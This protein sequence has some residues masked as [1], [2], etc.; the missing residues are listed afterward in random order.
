MGREDALL[1]LRMV[2]RRREESLGNSLRKQIWI[3]L[4]GGGE[5]DVLRVEEEDVVCL[6]CRRKI[7]E[8]KI[9]AVFQ[10]LFGLSNSR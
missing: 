5:S 7:E 10:A 8:V 2:E 1:I 4:E 3:G 9:P 6:L